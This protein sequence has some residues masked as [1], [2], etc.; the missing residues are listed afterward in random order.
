M[1]RT[2]L[3]LRYELWVTITRPSFLF[4][5]FG[6]P[7]IAA[8]LFAGVGALNS[9]GGGTSGTGST[10]ARTDGYVDQA[11][12]IRALP[13]DVPAG[14]LAPYPDEAAA[15]QA[16]AEK[17]IAGYYVISADFVQSGRLTRVELNPNPIAP[18]DDSYPMRWTLLF[19]LLGGDL[20]VARRIANPMQVQITQLDK[21]TSSQADPGLAFAVPYAT[22]LLFYIVILGSSSMLLYSVAGEK[23][24]RVI[25]ILMVSLTPHELLA[26]KIVGLGIAGLAQTGV[27]LASSYLLAG[28]GGR[29]AI[30]PPGFSLPPAQLR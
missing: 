28:F 30:L 6:L 25:E 4:A 23:K 11:G 3:V 27:W 7:L 5:M 29:S 24:N 12:L 2:L 9:A 13:P 16:L 14:R 26:G 17:K 10:A 15:R 8:L 18:G 20:N 1:R 19:N 22:T 21:D